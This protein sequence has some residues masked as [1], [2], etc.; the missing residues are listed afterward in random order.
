VPRSGRNEG[1]TLLI[2]DCFLH[3]SR[4]S[5]S[6]T[7]PRQVDGG[8]AFA[9]L[10]PQSITEGDFYGSLWRKIYRTDSENATSSRRVRNPS[11]SS[12]AVG[13]VSAR[14]NRSKS[15]ESADCCTAGSRKWSWTARVEK[16]SNEDVKR[17]AQ[18]M[19]EDHGK[20]NEE[21][22]QLAA[23]K[24]VNLPSEPSAK[25]K[26]KKERLSRLSGRE[27]DSVYV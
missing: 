24:G 20:A 13:S 2:R 23:K 6:S 22:K 4:D 8:T 25:Q 1:C 3:D 16:S 7:D 17:F 19:V 14:A 18:R 11:S 12:S 10:A 5:T 27:F 9:S 15:F 21:L 26:A